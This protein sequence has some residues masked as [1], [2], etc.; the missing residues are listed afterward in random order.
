M[1][2]V[3]QNGATL[4]GKVG[5]RTGN[6]RVAPPGAEQQRGLSE[7]H[8]TE[9]ADNGRSS[10]RVEQSDHGKGRDADLVTSGS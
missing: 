10:H 7:Q 9:L 8:G 3:L 6:G 5:K 4:P 1:V 2:F